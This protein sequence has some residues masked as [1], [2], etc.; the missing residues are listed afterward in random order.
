MDAEVDE[1]TSARWVKSSYS[2]DNGGECVELAMLIGNG[3]AIR[4]SKRPH[5]PVLRVPTAE[6]AAFRQSLKTGDFDTLTT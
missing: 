3:M 1:L 5:G 4:D 6:W 2:G